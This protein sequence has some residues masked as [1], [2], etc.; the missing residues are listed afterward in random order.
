MPLS[1]L[2]VTIT[3]HDRRH[4]VFSTTGNLAL[5]PEYAN[6]PKG[7]DELKSC[8]PWLNKRCIRTISL[9]KDLPFSKNKGK[10]FDIKF[11]PYYPACLRRFNDNKPPISIL[12]LANLL[13]QGTNCTF[14]LLK[15]VFY[16]HRAQYGLLRIFHIRNTV[17]LS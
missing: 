1:I 4:Y 9:L 3:S 5:P 2:F 13:C 6:L 15:I 16:T 17:F 12:F 10:G 8:S 11:F 14:L 7:L